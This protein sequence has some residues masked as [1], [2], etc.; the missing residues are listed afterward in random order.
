[1]RRWT[2]SKSVNPNPNFV[3]PAL[4]TY[5]SRTTLL[6]SYTRC[7]RHIVN[8]I[9]IQGNQKIEQIKSGLEIAP[10]HSALNFS[11]LSHL[12]TEKTRVGPVG[13]ESTQCR[14]SRAIDREA[15]AHR[16]QQ[17]LS[18]YQMGE[19]LQIDHRPNIEHSQCWRAY[20]LGYRPGPGYY[21]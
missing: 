17:R 8:G 21:L 1:M 19:E 5:R 4:Y 10:E 11:E 13:V 3:L 6:T 7:D 14:N 20:L 15:P 12:R 2:S 16:Q 18:T 9:E